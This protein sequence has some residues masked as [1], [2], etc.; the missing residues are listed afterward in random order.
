MTP[1]RFGDER[2]TP[3]V[4]MSPGSPMATVEPSATLR[5][6]VLDDPGQGVDER[7]VTPWCPLTGLGDQPTVVADHDAEALRAAD[8]DAEAGRHRSARVFSSRTELRMR[9]SARRL[10]KP[11]SGEASSMAKS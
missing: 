3:A 5:T 9:T 4:V 2:S 10:T 1:G 6:E 11:G 8:V 7:I